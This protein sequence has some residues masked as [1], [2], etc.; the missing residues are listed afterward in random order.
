M[1]GALVEVQ[2]PKNAPAKVWMGE[3]IGKAWR[4]GINPGGQVAGAIVPREREQAGRPYLDRLMSREEVEQMDR[5]V[6]A[7]KSS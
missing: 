5:E 7:R 1:G 3:A 4:L 2:V 6:A